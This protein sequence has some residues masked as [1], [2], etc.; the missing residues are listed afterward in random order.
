VHTKTTPGPPRQLAITLDGPPSVLFAPIYEALANGDFALGALHV[1]VSSAASDQTALT[2]LADGHTQIAIVS[3]PSVIAARASGMPVVAVGALESGPLEAIISLHPIGSPAALAGRTVAVDGTSLET[4]EL[5]SYLG[6]GGVAATQTRTIDAGTGALTAHKAYAA[7]G[8]W[9]YDTVALRLAHRH[10]SVIRIE[11]AGVPT[12]TDLA[13]V[14]RVGEARYDGAVLR[15]FLQSL[16]RGEQATA[17]DPQAVA[18]LLVR[19]NPRLSMRFELAALSATQSVAQP[20]AA[21]RPFG[22]QSPFAWQSF[23]SWMQTHGLIAN[24]SL[25]GDTITDEFLPGQGE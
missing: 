20:A 3:E 9:N 15:A 4:A 23:G 22:Y 8:R 7:I 10:P 11:A 17:S 16:T 2:E 18:R 25:A 24:A 1:T 14:V 12:F 19:I 5:E 6:S 13:I 21:G